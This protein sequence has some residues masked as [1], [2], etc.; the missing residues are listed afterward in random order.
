MEIKNSSGKIIGKTIITDNEIQIINN[1][2]PVLIIT[3]TEL[4]KKIKEKDE[5]V[6]PILW[7]DYNLLIE[8]ILIL[9]LDGAIL[10]LEESFQKKEKNILEKKAEE[11]KFLHMKELQ[12]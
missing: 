2:K 10:L 5:S 4:I 11:E 6:F 9:M 1:P 7:N 3:D 12:K 8:L